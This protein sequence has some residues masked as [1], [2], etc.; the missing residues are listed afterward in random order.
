MRVCS[1][2]SCSI[3]SV[4]KFYTLARLPIAAHFDMGQFQK[5]TAAPL[6]SGGEGPSQR[7]V[8]RLQEHIIYTKSA[9]LGN[10]VAKPALPHTALG[11]WDLR[12]AQ[13]WGLQH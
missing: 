9:L 8:P 7:A 12:T 2:S 3:P 4:G 13:G 11:D 6:L 5:D 10:S 1:E